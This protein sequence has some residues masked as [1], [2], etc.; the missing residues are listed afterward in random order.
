MLRPLVDNHNA[1]S[2]QTTQS[3]SE[4]KTLIFKKDLWT[5]SRSE[6]TW[7]ASKKYLCQMGNGDASNVVHPKTQEW[8]IIYSHCIKLNPIVCYPYVM[9]E[10]FY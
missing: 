8:N 7:E 5:F 6:L 4:K 3:K 10:F 1:T 9:Q 2:T